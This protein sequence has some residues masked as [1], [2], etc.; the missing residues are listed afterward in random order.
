MDLELRAAAVVAP[1]K[2]ASL[3]RE[4]KGF[5]PFSESVFGILCKLSINEDGYN[6]TQLGYLYLA[7]K[8]YMLNFKV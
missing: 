6:W 4:Y 2:P 7:R 1:V 3:T 8:S 5:L